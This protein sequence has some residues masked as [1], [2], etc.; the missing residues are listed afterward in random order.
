MN[1]DTKKK[2][3]WGSVIAGVGAVGYIGYKTYQ[4]KQRYSV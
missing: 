1:K 2:V 3:I 4:N